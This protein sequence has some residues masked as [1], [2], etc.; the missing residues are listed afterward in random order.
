VKCGIQLTEKP[1]KKLFSDV[2]PGEIFEIS[3][4]FVNRPSCT[5]MKLGY[6]GEYNAVNLI[7]YIPIQ[8]DLNKEVKLL[9]KISMEKYS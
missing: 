1:L 5:C 6:Y 3:F 7:T 9:G 4:N 2:L 8:V